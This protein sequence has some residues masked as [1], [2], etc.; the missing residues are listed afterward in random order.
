MKQ[1][2]S[3]LPILRY[4]S[5]V[6]LLGGALVF[7]A[8]DSG[9]SDMD[10]P[11]ETLT[12]VVNSTSSLSSLASILPSGLAETLDDEGKTYTVFAP[13]DLAFE[14]VDVESLTNNPDLLNSLLTYHV[15]QGE[16]LT[17]GDLQ[18]RSSVTTVEGQELEV[19]TE[20]GTV[21]VGGTEIAQANVEASNGVAHIIGGVLVPESFPRR[22]SYDLAAQS[23]SGAI[24]EG[25]DGTVTFREY[26]D[27]Q[28]LVTLELDDGATGANVSHPAH[29]HNNSASEGG[30]IEIYLTPLDGSGG[31]GTSARLVDRSFDNLVGFDGYVNIHESVENTENVVSQGNV[32]ANA[33]GTFGA[34]LQVVDDPSSATYALDA[35][36]N[37]GTFAPQGIPGQVQFLELTSNST[38]ATVRLDPDEDGEYEEGATGAN[39]SHP[40]HIHNNSASEGGSIEYY[41]SPVDGSDAAARS[42][43]LVTQPFGDLTSFDG[44]VNVHESV[45]NLGNVIS[46][47]NIGANASSTEGY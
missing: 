20:D 32:G 47:G 21:I 34:G 46:Q 33:T 16:A 11:E 43:K 9:G 1:L 30:S 18:D 40:A 17:T 41:L 29:I 25:V 27:T 36:I 12:G 24:P 15:V 14:N 42:S 38:L 39:V 45:E 31:G 26:S 19:E 13:A 22:F 23:N 35:N 2:R 44:Y 6:A 8:C 37:D 4:L 28:T 3:R 7:A 5:A 10:G